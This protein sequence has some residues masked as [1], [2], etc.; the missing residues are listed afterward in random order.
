MWIFLLAI[1]ACQPMPDNMEEVLQDAVQNRKEVTKV[2]KHYI[3]DSLKYEAAVFLIRNMK[4]H[5]RKMVLMEESQVFQDRLYLADS[6]YYSITSGVNDEILRLKEMKGWLKTNVYCFRHQYGE[7][8]MQH[9]AMGQ[10]WL[11]DIQALEADFLISHIDHAFECWQNSPYARHLSFDDFCEYILPYRAVS[12]GMYLNGRQLARWFARHL[13][14]SDPSDLANIIERYRMYIHHI[15]KLMGERPEVKLKAEEDIFFE[16]KRD[17]IPQCDYECQVLRAM[18][19][20]VAIDVNIGN[21]EYIGQHHHCV[22]L[23]SSGKYRPFHGEGSLSQEDEDWGYILDYKLNVYRSM[24]GAQKDSPYMLRGKGEALPEKFRSPALREV[25][26]YLKRTV[27]LDLKVPEGI[28][29]RLAWLYTYSRSAQG[30]MAVTWGVID[31]ITRN[32]HFANIVP[33]V[34]YFPAYLDKEGEPCFWGEPVFVYESLNYKAMGCQTLSGIMK[35]DSGKRVDL[36]INRKFPR[37]PKMLKLSAGMVGGKFYGANYKDGRDKEELYC[38]MKSPEACLNEYR[39]KNKKAWQYYIYEAPENRLANISILEFLADS[40][41]HYPHVTSPLPVEICSPAEIGRSIDQWVKLLPVKAD[42]SQEYD[43]NMQTSSGHHRLVFA[44]EQPEVVCCIR[45]APKNADNGVKPDENYD[46]FYWDKGWQHYANVTT[47]YHYMEFKDLPV[48]RLYWLRNNT[49]GREEVPFLIK[50]GK[51]AFIYYDVLTKPGHPEKIKCLNRKDWICRASSEET[52]GPYKAGFACYALDGKPE[53]HWH[54]RYTGQKPD[55]PH[56]I[57]IDT[58][59][60]VEANGFLLTPRKR[61]IPRNI[62]IEISNDGRHWEKTG[63]YQLENL[64]KEQR[65]YLEETKR[66]RYF[67]IICKDGYQ[68]TPY[69]SLV[70]IGLFK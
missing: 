32:A 7:L 64:G 63:E 67:R 66:F 1:E 59:S 24:F 12:T 14:K 57:W 60:K 3:H 70:E 9:R 6:L 44:L 29:N 31:S 55:Y 69:T 18:G 28:T 36:V 11:P 62:C 54:T 51:P 16:G 61:D 10:G 41:S 39:L 47:R 50:E 23:D 27:E 15:R 46:L 26:S 33:N 65:I 48:D 2:L 4:W 53:T 8:H 19:V 38:I 49:R 52:Q 42:H 25:T 35:S 17:C 21:R 45:M 34:L 40:S 56:W 13:E 5:R 22:V 68:T 37:K 20:P 30:Y 58:R 43:G